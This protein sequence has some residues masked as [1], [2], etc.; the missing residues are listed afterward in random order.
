MS[1]VNQILAAIREGHVTAPMIARVI[2]I[3][4][5]NASVVLQKMLSQG[6][7]SRGRSVGTGLGRPPREWA[8]VRTSAET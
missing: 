4:R 7:V 3:S 1:R 8:I 6:Q 2:G 5:N